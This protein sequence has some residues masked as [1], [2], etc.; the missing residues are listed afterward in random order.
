ME[1]SLGM[2]ARKKRERSR[3][4]RTKSDKRS[5]EGF[6]ALPNFLC[7]NKKLCSD[8]SGREKFSTLQFRGF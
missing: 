5:T 3:G 8:E 6:I 1:V 4:T 2:S 7:F